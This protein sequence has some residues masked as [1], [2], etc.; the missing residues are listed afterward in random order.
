MQSLFR[1]RAYC[2]SLLICLITLLLF[3]STGLIVF[4]Y[5]Q[6]GSIDFVQFIILKINH[7]YFRYKLNRHQFLSE[8]DFPKLSFPLP[9][10]NESVQLFAFATKFNKYEL[11]R[12]AQYYL[13]NLMSYLFNSNL[14]ISM[15]TAI[16]SGWKYQLVGPTLHFPKNLHFGTS[17]LEKIAVLQ[18]ALKCLVRRCDNA[19]K[20]RHLWITYLVIPSFCGPMHT[21]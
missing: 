6:E 9:F 17:Y 4:Q 13:T 15:E 16:L 21:M 18:V 7:I 5:K 14:C 8:S 10:A 19:F 1:R 3:V 12:N 2:N 11:T 20:G